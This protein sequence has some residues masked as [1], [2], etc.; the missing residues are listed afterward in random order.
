MT[1]RLSGFVLA[2]SNRENVWTS[3]VEVWE[4]EY[5][6]SGAKLKLSALKNRCG[7]SCYSTPADRASGVPVPWVPLKGP[8]P[9]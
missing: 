8:D 5:I 1:G 9:L 2:R 6:W 7:L 4:G 3:T